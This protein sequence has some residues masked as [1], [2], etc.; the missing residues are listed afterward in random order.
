MTSTTQDHKCPHLLGGA[1]LLG[2]DTWRPEGP[3]HSEGEGWAGAGSGPGWSQV[4]W[5]AGQLRV[6]AEQKAA[7]LGARTCQLAG[8]GGARASPEEL[9]ARVLG[10]EARDGGPVGALQ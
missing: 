7:V 2:E 10:W 9:A 3:G 5:G 4:F 6:G 1:C 8:V